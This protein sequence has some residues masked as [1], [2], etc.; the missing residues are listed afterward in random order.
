MTDTDGVEERI[1]ILAPI[2]RDGMAI[3]EVLRRAGLGS[4][5]CLSVAD[6]I[7]ALEA[8]AGAV[9]VGEEALFNGDA[10]GLIAWVERQPPW[11]DM[12]FIL[13][14][15]RQPSAALSRWR[16]GILAKLPNASL[17]EK[18]LDALTLSSV[19]GAA[20]RGRQRQY[21]VRAHIAERANAA[22]TLEQLVA[23]RTGELE[24][25]NAALRVEMDEREKAEAALRQA[26]KMEAVGQLTGGLAHDFNNM[27][28]G[29]SGSLDLMR[30]R[31][32]Q[33][34]INDLERYIEAAQGASKR[35]ASLTHRLLAFSRRQTLDP[36]PTDVNHLIGD[37]E[38]LIRRTVGPE[39][40]V[41]V[42]G[43][44]SAWT[45]LVD[46]NQLENALLNLCINS[47]DAM[48][49][50]GLLKIETANCWLDPRGARERDL[51]PGQ[52]VM[53][54]VSD[55]G[56]GMP[57]DVVARAFDPFYTTKPIGMGTG[58]GLSMVF[59]FA[60]Q[61]GGQ[62]RIYSE[63]GRGTMIC[64]YLP[65]HFSAVEAEDIPAEGLTAPRAEQ[66]ETV[67]VVDDEPTVRMLVVDVLND[68]GYTAIESPD[69]AGGLRVLQSDARV[70]LL[71]TDVGLPNGMNGRQM[72]DAARVVRPDLKV[73]FITGYAENAR[74]GNGQ[75]ERGMHVLTKP[76]AIETLAS[77]IKELI[78][79]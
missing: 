21:E 74:V 73:L 53:V 76:F 19:A 15:G 32:G 63:L 23:I 59:G 36:K 31:L 28:A 43:E 26:Q 54:S 42:A 62:A 34:R 69:G 79:E 8:G 47:R 33:G 71:I 58:L 11:S 10:A 60:R 14:T 2:G 77:R 51:P 75:L 37:M 35:A 1:L 24:A 27:L 67:L 17:L 56:S 40:K 66:G 64:L 25:A 4:L 5:I 61:S 13:L 29:I 55:T 30:T 3:A 16:Q 7:A 45:I 72:V 70:D 9:L 48:P 6:L 20:R 41:E 44:A 18:P 57:P 78:A 38:E 12:P 46:P 49:D 65:R 39:I 22:E 68:C 50:S 52:Y